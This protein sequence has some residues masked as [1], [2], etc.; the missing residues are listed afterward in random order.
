[1]LF[2]KKNL[3]KGMVA[4][5]VCALFAS[6]SKDP[7]FET[8]SNPAELAKIQYKE[9]FEKKYGAIAP[10][11]TWDFTTSFFDEV[12]AS[13]TRGYSYAVL[14]DWTEGYVHFTEISFPRTNWVRQKWDADAAFINANLANCPELDWEPY[15]T[16]SLRA[17]AFF[18][19]G[20][21]DG[22]TEWYKLGVHTSEG[23]V[24]VLKGK[25]KDE[26][27]YTGFRQT[28]NGAGYIIDTQNLVN[29]EDA[30][31]Y[32]IATEAEQDDVVTPAMKL[33]K[34]KQIRADGAGC[35][36]SV[37]WC[38]DCDHDQNQDYS[39]LIL[40]VEPVVLSKRYMIEDLGS[41]GDFD[42]NDIVVDVYQTTTVNNK[43]GV[44]ISEVDNAIIRA[45]GGTL[46]FTLTIGN[47]T[48]TKSAKGFT[49][50]TMYNT[51][52][53]I[54]YAHEYDNFPVAN[55]D[56]YTNNISVVVKRADKDA[57]NEGVHTITFPKAGDA[58]M[59]IAVDPIRKWMN[60]YASVPGEWFY[61]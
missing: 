33:T 4:L 36:G 2:M 8:A 26:F 52:G 10:N 46:D 55:W 60:E 1:M 5:C 45:M 11:Q 13:R 20:N 49:P 3:I 42:F 24:D 57:T 51:Q 17:W 56:P 38:F 53:T 41:I 16:G 7:G 21:G 23:N 32:A 59:I 6:C 29:A 14:S 43:N 25:T 40:L 48:W 54:D 22:K 30:Y 9:A 31:W 50:E 18:S 47:T 15:I 34:F 58:P 44:V 28:V 27:W 12:Q 61:E 19:H 39:D 37:Y 35:S